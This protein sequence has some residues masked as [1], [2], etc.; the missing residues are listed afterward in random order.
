MYDALHNGLHSL[1]AVRATGF[2]GLILALISHFTGRT[3]FLA[4]SGAQAG[5]DASTAGYGATYIDI[6]C[7]RYRRGKSLTP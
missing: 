1:Q 5:K 4:K 6:E 7:E 3:F 2:E